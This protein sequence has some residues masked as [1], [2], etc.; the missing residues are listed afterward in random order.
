MKRS[1]RLKPL[2]Y[3][4]TATLAIFCLLNPGAA[5]ADPPQEITAAYDSE[6]QT[7]TVSVTHKTTFP[8]LHYV[9]QI[10]IRK[11]GAPAGS[12]PFKSQPDKRTFTEIYE[13]PAA[14]GDVLEITAVCNLQG[15]KTA[16][17]TVGKATP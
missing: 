6:K 13:V 9:K 2:F 3:L 11:N 1:Y 5:I 4:L 16:T 15:D 14:E 8:G 12:Y 17:L 7:L 10:D